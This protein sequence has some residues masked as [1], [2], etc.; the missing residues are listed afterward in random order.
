MER[1]PTGVNIPQYIHIYIVT[2]EWCKNMIGA[3]GC[4]ERQST[5]HNMIQI[6]GKVCDYDK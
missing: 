1:T 6:D 2:E 5:A 4:R 3:K